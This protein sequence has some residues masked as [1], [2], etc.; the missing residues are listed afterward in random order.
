MYLQ[1][2]IHAPLAMDLRSISAWSSLHPK[3]FCRKL[4]ASSSNTNASSRSLSSVLP[5]CI[6]VVCDMTHSY[7]WHTHK[8]ILSLARFCLACL[9]VCNMWHDSFI[10]ATWLI[11]M[12]DV[13]HSYVQR[14]SFICATWLIHMCDM[15]HSYVWHG[16]FICV[17]WPIHMCDMTHSY[18]CHDSFICVTYVM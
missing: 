13:T 16:P 1:V 11:H 7:V 18:V 2:Y 14:D 5:V 8:R 17:T 9:H 12:C 4:D 6:C 10:C 3:V 15:A